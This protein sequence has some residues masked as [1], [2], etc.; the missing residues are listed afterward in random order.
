MSDKNDRTT[1]NTKYG[2]SVAR[3]TGQAPAPTAGQASEGGEPN[4]LMPKQANVMLFKP[5]QTEIDAMMNDASLEFAPQ[6]H[7]LEEGDMIAGVLEGEGPEAEF[8]QMDPVTKEQVTR[9]VKTWIIAA[10][11]GGIRLSLLSSVQL[12][13]KLPPFIGGMV[14]IVR[15]KD[16]KTNNGIFRVTN[17]MVAGPRQANGKPRSWTRPHVID[18]TALDAAPSAGALPPG[19]APSAEQGGEDATA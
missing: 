16:I 14:K 4:A 12:D 17:Y 11:D 13:K 1:G 18:A 19:S 15:G 3:A 6:V 8:T 2:A 9:T 10:P 5:S 7:K